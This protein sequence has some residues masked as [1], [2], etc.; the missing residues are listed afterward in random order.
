MA[1][2]STSKLDALKSATRGDV[3]TPGQPGYDEARTIWNAMIDRRPA[4]I[5]RCKDA[6]DVPHAIRFAREHGDVV[7]RKLLDVAIQR[8]IRK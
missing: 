1:T 2:F 6:T 3:L 4:V 5:V 7:G 8:E